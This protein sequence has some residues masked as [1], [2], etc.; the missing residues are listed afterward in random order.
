MSRPSDCQSLCPRARTRWLSSELYPS[1]SARHLKITR[2]CMMRRVRWISMQGTCQLRS[3]TGGAA[4]RQRF[5]AW[6][7][8]RGDRFACDMAAR[9]TKC[10]WLHGMAAPRWEA[11]IRIRCI[12]ESCSC[13]ADSPRAAGHRSMRLPGLAA[14]R[15]PAMH[16]SGLF[17]GGRKQT[18]KRAKGMHLI[19]GWAP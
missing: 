16:C 5:S 2:A 3:G 17:N 11:G 6:A 9:S 15:F 8:V 12:H 19:H 1:L 13:L 14:S 18:C 10:S 4:R 7:Y